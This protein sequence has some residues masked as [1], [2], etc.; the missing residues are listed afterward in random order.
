MKFPSK[1]RKIL[2]RDDILGINDIQ[3]ELVSTP[4]WKGNNYVRGMTGHE[5]DKFES[6]IIEMK[7]KSQIL[8]LNDIRAKLASQTICDEKGNKLF[9]EAD[10]K[11]LSGK[12]AAALQRIFEVAQRLSG[13]GNDDIKELTEGFEENP[14]GDS[15]SDSPDIS[16]V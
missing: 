9:T 6:S 13:I 3:I 2:T 8:H 1:S 12:S 15:A 16:E 7:G 14:F 4:E 11:A 10:I 5:R